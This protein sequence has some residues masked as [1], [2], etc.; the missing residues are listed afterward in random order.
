MP[1]VTS[2]GFAKHDISLSANT[3]TIV[4]LAKDCRSAEV[5][6]WDSTEPVYV[7]VNGTAATVAGDSTYALLIGANAASFPVPGEIGLTSVRLIS[8]A[9]ATVSVT[10]S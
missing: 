6:V 8:A 5:I 10:G 7:T 1:T 2:T 3:E 4:N 9:S